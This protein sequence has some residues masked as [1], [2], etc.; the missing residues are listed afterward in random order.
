MPRQREQRRNPRKLQLSRDAAIIWALHNK[1]P[2]NLQDLVKKTA[3]LI[4]V[5]N[6]DLSKSIKY[7]HLRYLVEERSIIKVLER[8]GEELYALRDYET[9]QASVKWAIE[10]FELLLFCRWPSVGEIAIRVGETPKATEEAVYRVAPR[11][12]WIPPP[13]KAQ[14]KNLYLADAQ[15]SARRRL[16]LA[17][18]IKLGCEETEY[19]KNNWPGEDEELQKAK[20]LPKKYPHHVPEV[21]AYRFQGESKERFHYRLLW[22]KISGKII[23]IASLGA[24]LVTSRHMTP[25]GIA[26]TVYT[27]DF[28]GC[29]DKLTIEERSPKS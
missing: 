21:E 6:Y 1:Q 17:A 25:K 8:D 18:W 15:S 13:S 14:E 26:R 16:E 19:V 23:G 4:T 11:I 9:L 22:P 12:G 3:E 10:D 7:D 5:R 29:L 20:E 24:L 2:T 28:N 27:R